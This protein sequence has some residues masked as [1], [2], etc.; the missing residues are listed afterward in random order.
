MADSP[1]LET[2]IVA[3]LQRAHKYLPR[4]DLHELARAAMTAYRTFE[5]RELAARGI[6]IE[7]FA[8]FLERK[9]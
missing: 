9:R 5:E 1:D 6:S 3:A 4:E 7:E 2:E 8:Q